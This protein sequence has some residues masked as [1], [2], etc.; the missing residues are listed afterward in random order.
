MWT[1]IVTIKNEL[2]IQSNGVAII[3]AII[4]ARPNVQKVIIS[5]YLQR[6]ENNTWVP[7]K[8]WSEEIHGKKFLF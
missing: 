1:N 7:V 2:I 8:N 3:E 4:T 5:S 6:Y